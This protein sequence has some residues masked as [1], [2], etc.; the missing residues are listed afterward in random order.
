MA[1]KNREKLKR[2]ARKSVDTIMLAN[3]DDQ[4]ELTCDECGESLLQ[5]NGIEKSQKK[6]R[7]ER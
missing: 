2:D 5:Q 6:P 3:V 4:G 1:Q 7:T